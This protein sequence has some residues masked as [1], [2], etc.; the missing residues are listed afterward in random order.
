MV[1]KQAQWAPT[2]QQEAFLRRPEYEVLYGGS[3]YSLKTDALLG[4]AI[5][6]REKYPKS[7]GLFIRRMMSEITKEGA[8]WERIAEIL[9]SRVRYNQQEHKVYFPNGSVEEFGHCNEEADKMAFQG[10]QYDDLCWDQLEQFTETQY[11]YIKGACR[12]AQVDPPQYQGRAIEPRIRCSANPGDVGHGWVRSYYIDVAPPGVPYNEVVRV[13]APDGGEIVIPRTRIYIPASVFDAVRA[14][15]VSADYIATLEAMPEP[16]RSAYLYGKWDIFIG[17][18][19][20]EFDPLVHV[21]RTGPIDDRWRRIASHD[22]GY[23]SPGH[24]LW[25]AVDPQGGV[26]I[27]REW[28]FKGLDPVE[29]A[30]GVL[31]R[32]GREAPITWA[33]PACWAERRKADLNQEQLVVLQEAGKL[34]LSKAEQYQQAGL[35]VQPANNQRIAGKQRIHTLLKKR[36]DGVPYLRVM[37]CCPVLIETLRSIQLDPNRTEDVMTAYL[38]DAVLR[39][40]A[41]DALRYLLMGVPTEATPTEVVVGRSMLHNAAGGRQGVR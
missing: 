1:T 36:L 24:H 29:I 3:K 7:H 21:V 23:A 35:T 2:V 27:Y 5:T 4:W 38:A 13:K 15:V 34:Q 32:Q 11:S 18:A 10:A 37:G 14:G 33:D 39:D 17:Q 26:I 9:G 41:Y 25:G 31:Y 16:Y 19:F 8:A 6:R 12:T 20:M 40:D 22:W 28:G 30:Q